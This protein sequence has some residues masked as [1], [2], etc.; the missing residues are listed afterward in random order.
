MLFL[1]LAVAGAA[2]AAPPVVP[3]IDPATGTNAIALLGGATLLVRSL[4]RK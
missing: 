1:T 4:R 2:L 3:E